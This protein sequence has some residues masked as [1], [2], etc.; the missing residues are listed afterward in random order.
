MIG[1]PLDAPF[2]FVDRVAVLLQRDVLRWKGK[3]EIGQ[4]APIGD[5]PP[6]SP[7]VASALPQEKRFQPMR[8]LRT[9]PHRILARAEEITQGFVVGRRNV[10][11]RQLTGAMQ[12]GER[13]AITPIGLDAIAAPL[14]HTRGIHHDA[15]FALGGQ[16][17][18]DPKAARPR[19]VHEP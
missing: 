2:R 7:G 18:V 6:R 5:R 15:L 12:P 4:P 14:R 13:V 11:G 8:G 9:Q 19:F 16:V 3:A 1:D 10:D 17:P